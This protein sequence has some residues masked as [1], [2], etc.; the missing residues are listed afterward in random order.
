[1]RAPCCLSGLWVAM[2]R[3]ALLACTVNAQTL[4][5]AGITE[6]IFIQEDTFSAPQMIRG[7]SR[8]PSHTDTSATS[9]T[10]FHSI[11]YF[12][13]ATPAGVGQ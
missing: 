11:F 2:V 6:Y 12:L 4:Y 1:M 13:L 10:H 7:A 8:S 5:A 3:N 9:S